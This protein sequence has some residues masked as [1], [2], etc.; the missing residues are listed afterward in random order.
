MA[1]DVVNEESVY[2]CTGNPLPRTVRKIAKWLLNENYQTAYDSMDSDSL[3]PANKPPEILSIQQAQGL[4]L[5]DILRD[6]HGY[7]GGVQ[8][9]DP[10]LI[11]LYKKL[12]E[13]EYRLDG[14]GDDKLQLG[15][16]VSIFQIIREEVSKQVDQ[17]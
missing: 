10:L 7:L 4:A 6:I 8:L 9:P 16:L 1:F 13:I 12:A 15:A 3:S 14:G 2:M 17:R 11:P 5:Q